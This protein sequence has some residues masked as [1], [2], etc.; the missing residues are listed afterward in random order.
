M[1]QHN[2]TGRWGEQLA[3]EKLAAA[4]YAIVDHNV[5][6]GMNEIDF[7]AMKGDRII[8]VE[9]KT[10]TSDFTDPADAIDSRKVAR[11]CRVA[12]AYVNAYNI[13]HEVQIDVITICGSPGSTIPPKVEH[14]EDAF[15]PPLRTR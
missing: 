11:L 5:H 14:Y 2:D 10:R 12:N 3:R 15:R 8:F 7:I 4:G 1:A 13:P 6:F 9:V